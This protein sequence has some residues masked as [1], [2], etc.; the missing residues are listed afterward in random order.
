MKTHAFKNKSIGLNKKQALLALIFSLGLVNGL[1]YAQFDP[2]PGN[3][4]DC[5][6]VCSPACDD[7]GGGGDDPFCELL[8]TCEPDCDPTVQSCAGDGDGDGG[9]EGA[10]CGE[11]DPCG[12]GL[13]GGSS[14]APS[15]STGNPINIISGNKYKKQ[16][17]LEALPGVLGLEFSRHYNSAYSRSIGLG[18]GWRHS[19]STILWVSK[20]FAPGESEVLKLQQADGRILHFDRVGGRNKGAQYRT[21]NHADGYITTTDYGYQWRWRSGRIASFDER[22]LLTQVEQNG[23]VMRLRYN[24][25]GRLIGV[26]DP[27]GRRLTFYY[28]GRRLA[29]F[30]DPAG[31]A[32]QFKYD[33]Q[34]RLVNVIR[35][36]KSVRVYHYQD[37]THQWHLTGITDELGRRIQ[38][39]GYDKLGRA[40][41]STKDVNTEQVSIQYDDDNNRR[42]LTDS[43]GN[44]TEYLLTEIQGQKLIAEVRGPGC[45]V[46]EQGDVGYEYNSSLQV[47]KETHKSGLVLEYEYDA[48]GR[49]SHQYRTTFRRGRELIQAFE[50]DGASPKIM[51]VKRP[52]I[53]PGKFLTT[54]FRYSEKGQVVE[55]RE[56]GYEPATPLND[57]NF[58]MGAERYIEKSRKLKF[59]YD[60]RGQ[61]TR[62]DGPRSGVND[63]LR[64]TY[65]SDGRLATLSLPNGQ[66]QKVLSYDA[67]GHPTK[68]QHSN[69]TPVLISYNDFGKPTSVTR[70]LQSVT[71]EYDEL[72]ELKKVTDPFGRSTLIDYDLM[73]RVET[74][75]HEAG[76]S[77]EIKFDSEHRVLGRKLYDAQGDVLGNVSYL[78][79]AYDRLNQVNDEL[80]N[81]SIQYSYNDYGE[82]SHIVNQDKQTTRFGRSRSGSILQAWQAGG[83]KFLHFD[84]R[85]E[86]VG[87]TDAEGNTTYQIKNDF[88]QVV[89]Y[90]SG[91]RGATYF[92]YD[93]A[94][95][96]IEQLNADN[97]L[98][99]FDY[100]AANRVVRKSTP[101][102][103]IDFVYDPQSGRLASV[104]NATGKEVFEYDSDYRVVSH[105]R[106]ME[107]HEFV[108]RYKYND[109]WQL[110]EKVLPDGQTLHYLYH[111]NGPAKGALKAVTRDE[112]FGLSETALLSEIDDNRW[113][114]E[115]RITFGNGLTRVSRY[116]QQ[117]RLSSTKTEPILDLAFDRDKSGNV[118]QINSD[119]SPSSYAYDNANR[120]VSADLNVGSF[121]FEYDKNGNRIRRVKTSTAQAS[122]ESSSISSY[123]RGNRLRSINGHEVEYNAVGSPIKQKSKLGLRRYE[124]NASQ[125]PVRLYVDG[126][127]RAEYEYNG[128]G[129]RVKKV[130]YAS[131]S[132]EKNPQVTYFLYEGRRLVGEVDGNGD[133]F[134]QYLYH[135]GEP[136]VKLNGNAAYYIHS[137]HLGTPKLITDEDQN[138][139]WKGVSS[140]FGAVQLEKHD[141]EFH[142]RFRGQYE[143]TESGTYYNYFRD[144][145]PEV[146]RYLTNDPIGLVGGVNTYAYV[147]GNPINSI[148]PL[149]L[150]TITYYIIND[151]NRT[152]RGASVARWAYTITDLGAASDPSLPGADLD[153]S[154]VLLFDRHYVSQRGTATDTFLE[155]VEDTYANDP[156]VSINTTLGIGV[157][158]SNTPNALTA[159]Q[160][161][162]NNLNTLSATSFSVEISDDDA[163]AF[164]HAALPAPTGN[165]S[166]DTG[167][168]DTILTDLLP[169]IA[170]PVANR[171]EID[172]TRSYASE[173]NDRIMACD[174]SADPNSTGA[175]NESAQESWELQRFIE[176]TRLRETGG[177]RDCSQTG[178]PAGIDNPSGQP[179]SYGLLQYVGLTMVGEL[180]HN[181]NPNINDGYTDQEMQDL[182]FRDENDADT[183]LRARLVA[184]QTR[185]DRAFRIYRDVEAA[186]GGAT[187]DLATATTAAETH[188][189]TFLNDTGLTD[190]DFDNL[191]A[192]VVFFNA[193]DPY[194][195]QNFNN[196]TAAQQQTINTAAA[197][198]GIGAGSRNTYMR[199]RIEN[200][201]RNGFATAAI[202]AET[203]DP[204]NP[205]D[206]TIREYLLD[207][208]DSIF[209][210]TDNFY[211]AITP[212]LRNSL[213][214]QR[215]TYTLEE[216]VIRAAYRHNT[217]RYPA[218]I[219]DGQSFPYVSGNN[220]GVLD[221]FE[222][223]HCLL[224]YD[225][226]DPIEIAPL[227]P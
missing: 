111:Q 181:S 87:I 197:N 159:F 117:G 6:L 203:V 60:N 212:D 13:A 177:T 9:C 180:V 83:S 31:N 82:L 202:F 96:L 219:A 189:Q 174:D 98:I 179:A 93:S 76:P 208:N 186:V 118:V 141:I 65:D 158:D 172:P 167:E 140:P 90:L 169:N 165:D 182:G 11:T 227:L 64:L 32:T 71:Y 92:R 198:A 148:D 163:R 52:S 156:N 225:E 63:E 15:G 68:L 123:G 129:E 170:D 226:D 143:D 33:K 126:Q 155:S 220:R 216:R 100:D 201:A 73:S 88:G 107:G 58:R 109:F 171:G 122:E 132:R 22:G 102:D 41:V 154:T 136:T 72:G 151:L 40:I 61:L 25:T 43:Q 103:R 206:P 99:K 18:V 7:S 176:A 1:V 130:V 144:Y 19:Y 207:N 47:T 223:T 108:T 116:D 110:I 94:G 2:F 104:E 69:Q 119:D 26:R 45:S 4:V 138:I 50:Y 115:T 51:L 101:D 142:L 54:E 78:Y 79:D 28:E 161:Y 187:T 211:A 214:N 77:L 209:R 53:A 185:G 112:W 84:K 218:T 121:R 139:A 221:Y 210:D 191:I 48:R 168:H 67:L 86:P 16:T 95:N 157:A 3:T 24:G 128:F 166:C 196:L 75:R 27:Q 131:G 120:L 204:A 173:L 20:G 29:G 21:R 91:D 127:L 147:G 192:S 66:T 44:T 175:T 85:G 37:P 137:D 80:R 17:D 199:S 222:V 74:V 134:S 12:G 14:N 205:V 46:C 23:Q 200:E 184:A 194:I 145:D 195:G 89:T 183:G 10:T 213:N 105:S 188:R 34:E 164:I 36:N 35:P 8:G 114:K 62:I 59:E 124:Y 106:Q 146:G 55:I 97:Q 135:R 193:I 5:T 49:V 215:A 133:I 153:N 42:V 217:G 38:S 70:G 150:A 178:C 39:Y 81:E 149:G 113:D 224:D 125:R 30:T 162:Y 57:D 56:F 152:Q 190:A 160:D